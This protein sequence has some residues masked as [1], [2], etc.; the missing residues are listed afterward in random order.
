MKLKLTL[1]TALA[2]AS[3][4]TPARAADDALTPP[5]P[6]A[7]PDALK[8]YDVDGDGKLSREEWKAFVDANKPERPKNPWDTNGDGKLSEEEIKAAR[9]KIRAEIEARIR[10]RFDEADT[11]DNGSLSEEEF[12]ATLPD[13]VSEE[14]AKAAFARIDSDDDDKISWEEFL[15]AY[16]HGKA[17]PP[18]GPKPGRPV[19][20]ERPER[21]EVPGL[22]EQLKPFDLNGDG[23][24]SGEEIQKAIADGSWPVPHR[25]KPPG[26]VPPR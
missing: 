15:K 20:P 5:T 9:E 19:K 6:R 21:P 8:P 22:P 16:G 26:D 11:D 24:L 18:R 14:R 7:L 3:G 13:D 17:A 4:F 12:L 23:V 2:V 25:P 10:A 1:F